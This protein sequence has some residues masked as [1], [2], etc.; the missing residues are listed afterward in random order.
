[1]SKVK[2][3]AV[4]K[5][6]TRARIW[7]FTINNPD[8][9]EESHISHEKFLNG[10]KSMV[11][12]IEEGEKKTPHIQGVVQMKNQVTFETMKKKL[13]EGAHIEVCRNFNASKHYCQKDS[14]RIRGPYIWPVVRKLTEKEIVKSVREWLEFGDDEEIEIPK[15]SFIMPIILNSPTLKGPEARVSEPDGSSCPPQPTDDDELIID[16]SKSDK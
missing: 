1:M 10:I 9:K 11:W 4:K 3:P 5:I 12:Q 8:E 7:T 15:D 6:G 2:N 13:P 16:I 14:G